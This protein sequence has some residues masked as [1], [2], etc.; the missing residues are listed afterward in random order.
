MAPVLSEAELQY[1]MIVTERPGHAQELIQSIVL[2]V[3]GWGRRGGGL[4]Q[5]RGSFRLPVVGR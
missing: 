2:E 1:N 3:R 5:V 4:G